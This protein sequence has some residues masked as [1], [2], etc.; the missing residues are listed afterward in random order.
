MAPQ[1]DIVIPVYNEG[2][3]ILSTL[4][5]LARDVKSPA[6]VLIVYDRTE[7]DTLPAIRNS[8]DAYAGLAIEFVRNRATGAHHAVMTGFAALIADEKSI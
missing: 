7:D 2:R 8:P 1:L 4:S 6:R 5:A 3:N